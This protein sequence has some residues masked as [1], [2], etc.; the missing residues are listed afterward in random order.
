MTLPKFY[1]ARPLRFI[2]DLNSR[3]AH[4]RC[5]NYIYGLETVN[6]QTVKYYVWF[7]RLHYK[8]T[9]K[10]LETEVFLEV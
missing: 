7:C 3:R 2:T 1:W 5:S 9:I 4:Y 6:I 10:F 8:T